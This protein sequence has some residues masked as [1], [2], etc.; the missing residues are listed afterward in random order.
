V[1]AHIADDGAPAPLRV[2]VLSLR[3]LLVAL[4]VVTFSVHAVW[5]AVVRRGDSDLNRRAVRTLVAGIVRL[6]GI[7]V[8][9]EGG[10]HREAHQPCVY[11]ANHRGAFDLVIFGAVFPAR[12]IVVGKRELRRVPI[13]GHCFRAFG[14]V[15]I[16]RAD[17]I[18][19]VARLRTAAEAIATRRVSVWLFPE[20]TRNRSPV[21]LLPFKKGP[22][23]LA[24]EAGVPVVPVVA[25]STR[26]LIDW[27]RGRFRH[28]PIRVRFLP[29]I[30]P[31]KSGDDIDTVAATA[32][33][34][35]LQAMVTLGT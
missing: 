12:T 20:G 1:T 6:T 35:M 8:V 22:F 29:P 10:E 34:R 5:L 31:V 7:R 25:A 17:R 18:D 32:H 14:N 19:A 4:W 15:T 9:L 13:F 33:E 28:D 16:D 27:R 30:A 26:G 3:L 2:V 11:L 21:P 23:H 24:R